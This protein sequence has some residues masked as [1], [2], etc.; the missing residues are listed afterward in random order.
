M[1]PSWSLPGRLPTRPDPSPPFSPK[2]MTRAT[3]PNRAR[4]TTLST[5]PRSGRS[6]C[7]RSW[8]RLWSS[9]DA[10]SE[11][12]TTCSIMPWQPAASSR[13][14]ARLPQRPTVCR[15]ISLRRCWTSDTKTPGLMARSTGWRAASPVMGSRRIQ[16]GRRPCATTPASAGLTSPADLTTSCPAPGARS[17]SCSRLGSCRR[18]GG[19]RPW[20][21]PSNGARSSSSASTRPPQTT[22][23][24]GLRS[25]AATG[26]SSA[27]P[28]ST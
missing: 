13:L 17:R 22:P 19:R 2:C 9:T 25:R 11:H 10:S 23:R 16:T 26:G 21:Q 12:A 4:D 24:D 5:A 15:A 3:G 20:R 28:F 8:A 27:S 1:T 7:S 14:A 18:R 6:L